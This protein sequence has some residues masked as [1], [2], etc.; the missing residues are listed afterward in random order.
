[1]A[2]NNTEFTL[3]PYEMAIENCKIIN[4]DRLGDNIWL[5][6]PHGRSMF[7]T[8]NSVTE[9]CS[10]KSTLPE[11][12]ENYISRE[13]GHAWLK[14][15]K[16]VFNATPGQHIYRFS[17]TDTKIDECLDIYFIYNSQ[18]DSPKKS[19][20]YMKREEDNNV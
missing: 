12:Y 4:F 5:R 19:Y 10:G 16:I 1:M 11:E 2:E 13:P 20:I 9:I 18:N 8:L 3:F 15:K 6:L 17:F 14:V 7:L